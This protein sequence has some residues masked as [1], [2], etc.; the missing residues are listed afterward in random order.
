MTFLELNKRKQSL[1]SK[2]LKIDNETM[3]LKI[4]KLIDMEKHLSNSPLSFTVDELKFE[5]SEAEKESDSYNQVDLKPFLPL[6][7]NEGFAPSRL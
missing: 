6:V 5:I 7:C 2:I 4:E 1:V 3:I